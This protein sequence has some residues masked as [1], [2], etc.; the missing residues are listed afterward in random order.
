VKVAFG[1]VLSASGPERIV[2]SGAATSVQLWLAGVGSAFSSA[3][4]A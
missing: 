3:F 1:L 4:S 2:V